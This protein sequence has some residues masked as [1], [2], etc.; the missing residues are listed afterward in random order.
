MSTE[1]WYI[2]CKEEEAL[3]C[4]HGTLV[5]MV[6]VGRGVE[7]SSTG[8]QGHLHTV[9]SDCRNSR[10]FDQKIDMERDPF[11]QNLLK[12]VFISFVCETGLTG[13]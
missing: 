6:S 2:W 13:I 11:T 4:E 3:R 10:N 8:E 1:R 7:V 12:F 5:H 9:R